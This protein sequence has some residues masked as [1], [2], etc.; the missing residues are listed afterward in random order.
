MYFGNRLLEQFSNYKDAAF[1]WEQYAKMSSI[2][3]IDG[4][5]RFS[6]DFLTASPVIKLKTI[7]KSAIGG[8]AHRFVVKFIG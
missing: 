5:I 7:E 8:L 6:E 4:S 2:H 3:Y 1:R